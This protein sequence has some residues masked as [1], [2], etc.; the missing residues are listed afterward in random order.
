MEK[1]MAKKIVTLALG[2]ALAMGM[3]GFALAQGSLQ[4]DDNGG[5]MPTGAAN[6]GVNSGISTNSN[7]RQPPGTVGQRAPTN[8]AGIP[9]APGVN[10]AIVPNSKGGK[11]NS[12]P[13]SQH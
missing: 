7:D 3:S 13:G 11:A 12:S 6:G 8:S 5:G 1:I 9:N 4:H 10:G 2:A